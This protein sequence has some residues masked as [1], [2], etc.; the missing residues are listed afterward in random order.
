MA[1]RKIETELALSGEKEFNDQ[2]KAANSNLKTLRS[3]MSVLTDEFKDNADSSEALQKKQ[4]IL[5]EQLAQQKEVVSALTARHKKAVEAYGENSAATDKYK[6]DLNAATI[7]LHSFEREL[8][9]NEQALSDSES[10]AEDA[11]KSVKDYGKAIEQAADEADKAEHSF[12]GVGSSIGAIGVAAGKGL[13]AL[14]GLALGGFAV[15][16]KAALDAAEAGNPAFKGLNKNIEGLKEASAGAQAAV[17]SVLLPMLNSLSTDGAKLLNDFSSEMEAAAGDTEKQGAIMGDYIA[18]GVGLIKERLPEMMELGGALI[19]GLGAGLIDAAP[20]LVEAAFPLLDELIYGIEEAAP[21]LGPIALNLV[22]QLVSNLMDHSPRLLVTGINLLTEMITGLAKAA[23][24]LVPAA[25][26]V[27]SA[28]VVA[29]LSNAPQLI[30]AG[31]QLMLGLLNGVLNGLPDFIHEIPFMIHVIVQAFKDALP[32]MLSV[33]KDLIRG[34]W[35]GAT[36]MKEWLFNRVKSLGTD[37][38]KHIKSVFGI[39]SPSKVMADEVGK[40]NAQGIGVGFVR[41]MK[42][43]QE[44]MADA[45]PTRFDTDNLLYIDDYRHVGG[46]H[47]IGRGKTSQGGTGSVINMYFQP[48]QLTEGDMRMACRIIN[49]ELGEAM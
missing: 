39:H 16:G 42:K 28:L 11:E 44:I 5:K 43:Q 24:N 30:T 40:P 38:V 13:L 21:E 32:E 9:K 36:D 49:E 20:D 12:E 19:S 29:L 7:K 8:Q 34:L 31:L 23:P 22:L 37:L 27:V 47:R 14:G 33:G 46:S 6:Q 45:I 41:E 4:A 10:A 26:E 17:G 2:L 48:K 18:K 3:D 1:T 35:Q 25:L 15:M